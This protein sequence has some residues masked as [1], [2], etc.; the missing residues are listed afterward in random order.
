SVM[1]VLIS[2]RGRFQFST[3]NAYSV[4]TSMPSRADVSTTSRTESMPARW[5]STRGRC[6]C[7][8]HRPLPSIMIAMCAGSCSKLTCRASASSG[9]PGGI[10]ATSC[11][12]D[13]GGPS[14]ANLDSTDSYRSAASLSPIVDPDEKQPFRWRRRARRRSIAA[15]DRVLHRFDR[16]AA[17]ADVHERANECADHVAQKTVAGDLVEHQAVGKSVTTEVTVWIGAN[18]G[19]GET[20]GQSVS[21]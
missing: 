21:S 6:R 18:G 14:V 11:S 19:H 7:A 5:P 10:H 15:G 12:S 2:A 4:S 20:L 16:T 8:A 9:E 13:N 17:S 3:E 1:S